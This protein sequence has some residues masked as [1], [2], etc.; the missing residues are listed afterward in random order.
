[1]E[2]RSGDLSEVEA[3]TALVHAV[4]GGQL[5]AW[6]QRM[7]QALSRSDYCL[8]LAFIGGEPVGYG[9]ANWCEPRGEDDQA[10]A[11][12]YLT[13]LV[14]A[15]AWRRRGI[16]EELTRRRLT[17]VA[18]RPGSVVL[19]Q[20]PQ[21]RLP[22][23]ARPARLHRGRTSSQLPGQTLRRRGRRPDARGPASQRRPNAV[24][25]PQKRPLVGTCL[26]WTERRS[27]LGGSL[28]AALRHELLQRD[29]IARAPTHRGI[30][31][32]RRGAQALNASLGVDVQTLGL[33][34]TTG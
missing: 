30:I 27:H 26:D 13:G 21:P 31:V 24:A 9:K 1:M 6:R 10:T 32:I 20:R 4:Y 2:Y 15:P 16:G 33:D 28:A 23:T 8:L 14:V 17:W 34:R 12:M 22:R 29:W 19:H 11:G 5:Q 3:V 7:H 25:D 18:A